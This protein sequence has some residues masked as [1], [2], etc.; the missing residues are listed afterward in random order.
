MR[1]RISLMLDE[2]ED[3][4]TVHIAPG[5]DLTETQGAIVLKVNKRGHIMPNPVNG[6]ADAP[7]AQQE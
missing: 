7:D 3:S 1:V 5:I 4:G 2:G 6:E